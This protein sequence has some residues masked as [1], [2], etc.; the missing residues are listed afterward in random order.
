MPV[1]GHSYLIL[2]ARGHPVCNAD[3][4]YYP[5]STDDRD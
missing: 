1:H 4:D 3:Y 2:V 5:G